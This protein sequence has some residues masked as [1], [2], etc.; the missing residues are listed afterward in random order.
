VLLVLFQ[1]LLFTNDADFDVAIVGVDVAFISIAF[2]SIVAV[3]SF[4][5][6]CAHVA[7]NYIVDVG[8]TLLTLTLSLPLPLQVLYHE[9]AT[10]VNHTQ[11]AKMFT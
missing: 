3:A 9:L 11:Y 6:T 8:L 5:D 10:N 1:L 4:A 7:A 2:A